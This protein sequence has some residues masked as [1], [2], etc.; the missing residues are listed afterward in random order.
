MI[1]QSRI[2]FELLNTYSPQFENILAE[3]LKMIEDENL[4][5]KSE[6]EF[7]KSALIKQGKK[8]GFEMFI[9]ILKRK[10]NAS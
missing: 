8:Q 1:E 9:Y 7:L 5:E 3:G 2:Y 6:W 10:A 4:N